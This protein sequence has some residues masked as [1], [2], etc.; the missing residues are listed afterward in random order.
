MKRT[1]T[2][3]N[4]STAFKPET[5]ALLDAVLTDAVREGIAKVTALPGFEKLSPKRQL[6]FVTKVANEITVEALA[7]ITQ[8]LKSLPVDAHNRI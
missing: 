7:W 1:E 5:I 2:T 3:Q 4:R 6:K 8:Q